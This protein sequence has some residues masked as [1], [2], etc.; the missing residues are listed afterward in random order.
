MAWQIEAII[1][2]K[3]NIQEYPQLEYFVFIMCIFHVCQLCTSTLLLFSHTLNCVSRPV[4]ANPQ[5]NPR[6]INGTL[7]PVNK[8]GK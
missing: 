4:D 3:V 8:N 2:S 7:D 5:E 6:K 1:R